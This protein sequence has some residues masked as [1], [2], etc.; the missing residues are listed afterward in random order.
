MKQKLTML[1]GL[2]LIL[3]L[4]VSCKVALG[5]PTMG[6]K[7]K[8]LKPGEVPIQIRLGH[9][10]KDGKP[11][12]GFPSYRAVVPKEWDDTLK[13]NLTFEITGTD[14]SNA[15]IT[16]I[17]NITWDSIKGGT[18]SIILSK[19]GIYKLTMKAYKKGTSP[20]QLV[21][22]SKETSI[23]I[24]TA[25]VAAFVLYPVRDAAAPEGE[26]KLKIKFSNPARYGAGNNERLIKQLKVEI[27]GKTHAQTISKNFGATFTEPLQDVP[28]SDSTTGGEQLVSIN[29]SAVKPDI[30]EV[31]IKAFKEKTIQHLVPM[32]K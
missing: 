25:P 21:L 9:L 11:V 31:S 12:D 28:S 17:K 24:G 6:N 10:D 22:E 13:G 14:P 16:P 32:N 20:L 7:P 4:A 19:T 27:K 2:A 5:T 30:Y 26:I 15:S 29:E 18:A 3:G 8:V 1:L 23:D